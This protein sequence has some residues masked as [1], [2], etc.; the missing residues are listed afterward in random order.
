MAERLLADAQAAGYRT[1]QHGELL[2]RYQALA[3]ALR[4]ELPGWTW[5]E[6]KGGL[7]IWARLPS[8][9]A[10]RFAHLAL[11]HG[12]AVATAQ[13]LSCT[14]AHGDRVRLSFAA[15]IPVLEEGVRR[16]GTA[17]RAFEGS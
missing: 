8:P 2:G 14:S 3:A 6:P 15:P 9:R 4:R 7:S 1:R 16:L 10:D 13:A 12:V 17:W 5:P 11:R